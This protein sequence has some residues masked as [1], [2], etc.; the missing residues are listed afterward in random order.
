MPISFHEKSLFSLMEERL[1]R[2]FLG[3][4]NTLSRN[5]I[6]NAA[7]EITWN[8]QEIL[9]KTGMSSRMIRSIL[10]QE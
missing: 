4:R 5:G 2:D 3:E 10:A 1:Q 6:T 7:F 9:T 8:I